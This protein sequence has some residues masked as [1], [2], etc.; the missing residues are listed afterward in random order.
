MVF[1]L[2]MFVIAIAVLGAATGWVAGLA[3][4]VFLAGIA[5]TAFA[6]FLSTLE[7]RTSQL[8]IR[9]DLAGF[10]EYSPTE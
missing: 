7:V 10:L 1:F 3:L 4:L 8:A 5:I 9:Q 6:V 2:D